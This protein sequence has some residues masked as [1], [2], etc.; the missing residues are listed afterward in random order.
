MEVRLRTSYPRNASRKGWKLPHTRHRNWQPS[1]STSV[2]PDAR[3]TCRIGGVLTKV[4]STRW[5]RSSSV[6]RAV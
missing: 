1:T 5:L 6:M 2:T 3:A 4:T